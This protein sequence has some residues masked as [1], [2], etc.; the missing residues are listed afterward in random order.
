MK[1]STEKE[2][3]L[4][5]PLQSLPKKNDPYLRLNAVC[6]Y[7][8][9]FPLDFPFK[10]LESSVLGEK[11]ID[12]FCGRGTSN[13]AARLRGMPSIGIDSSPIACAI[14]QAKFTNTTPD[15]II[16]LCT[17][18]LGNE[19]KPEHIPDYRFW[20][21]CYHPSTLEQICKLRDTFLQECQTDEAIALRALVLGILHGPANKTV[22]SYLSNQMPRTYAPKPNYSVK[23]WTGRSLFPKMIDVLEIVKRKAHYFF[24]S[25][26]PSVSGGILKADS[27]KSIKDLP[28]TGFDW[29]ITSPP[30][31]NMK[32]YIPDQWIRNWFLGGSDSV[33]YTSYSQITHTKNKFISDL[34]DVW[35]NVADV[36]NPDAKLI[37]RFGS[38]PSSPCDPFEVLRDSIE[39]ADCGWEMLKTNSAGTSSS[40]KRQAEQFMSGSGNAREEIDF[41]AV[42]K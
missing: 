41:Y 34:A 38:L 39:K 3:N 30:Y 22:P 19:Q 16:K 9:M 37:I 6:P 23:Y 33:E 26:P 1:N 28:L 25:L 2:Q 20:E 7:Y 21:L 15:K 42:L 4:D 31:Y 13:F 24:R 18:I 29:V 14:A 32:T 12:P 36:C 10:S 17:Q 8:T 35:K 5:F 40:G 27:R 11:V